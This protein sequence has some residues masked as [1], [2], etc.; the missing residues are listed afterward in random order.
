MMGGGIARRIG[1]GFDDATDES[2]GGE[3]ANNEFA[4]E[5]TRKGDSVGGQ[6][7]AA[8]QAE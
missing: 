1:F 4:D 5:E 2:G 3:F 8:K 6:L 7:C